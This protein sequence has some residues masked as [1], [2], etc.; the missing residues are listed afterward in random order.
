MIAGIDRFLLREIERSVAQRSRH[1][2]RDLA[3]A[4]RYQA[5]IAANR[6]RLAGI[7][8]LRDARVDYEAPGGRHAWRRVAAGPSES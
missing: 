3:S 5:S 1:W 8:G 6:Q 7:L 4:E 2:H